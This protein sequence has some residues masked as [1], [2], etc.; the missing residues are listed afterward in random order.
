VNAS[1][2]TQAPDVAMDADGD[3]VVVWEDNTAADAIVRAQRFTEAG[4]A[5]GS[6]IAVNEPTGPGIGSFDPSVAIDNAGRFVVAWERFVATGNDDV[7]ARVFNASGTAQTAELPVATGTADQDDTE[8]AMDADGDVAIAWESGS[9]DDDVLARRY[10]SAGAPTTS[11]FPVNSTT[12]GTQGNVRVGLDAG[13]GSLAA[14]WDSDAGGDDEVVTRR[15]NSAGAPLSGE[16]AV[17]TTDAGDQAD[18]GLGVDA[19]GRFVVA[20]E[21]DG[22]GTDVIARAFDPVT[23]QPPDGGGGGPPPPDPQCVNPTT[24]L[25]SCANPSGRVPG[26]CGP[27]FASIFPACYLPTVPPTVC[28]PSF[29][30]ILQA[31]QLKEARILACGG[32]GTILPQCN[33]PP[34]SVPQVCGPSSGT[35]LPACTG[36]N[37]LVL[38]CGPSTGTV[39]PPCNFATKIKA[40]L[41]D[42]GKSE[43]IDL[44]LSCPPRGAQASQSPGAGAAQ[45]KPA[46][47]KTCPLSTVL[48]GSRKAL[49]AVLESQ[50]RDVAGSFF[51]V[52][53]GHR[54][55]DQA[56]GRR[57]GDSFE[58][59]A[60]YYRRTYLPAGGKAPG[61]EFG[62]R[63]RV[64]RGLFAQKPALE[65]GSPL[66]FYPY[67]GPVGIYPPGTNA[68]NAPIYGW[69]RSLDVA[70]NQ[71]EKLVR[72]A[73]SSSAARG[74]QIP[75]AQSARL[76]KPRV[77]K[78]FRIRA[79][80]RRRVRLKLSRKTVGALVKDARRRRA[81]RVPVRI[82]V[83]YRGK[84]SGRRIPVARVIDLQLRVKKAKPK[85][86]KR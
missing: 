60:E 42:P 54:A 53:L 19:S 1:T 9:P 8:S 36:G 21:S 77:T 83:S 24:L 74:G 22:T 73:K 23:A 40:G 65:A 33:L 18:P 20:W 32:F 39:L 44:T 71:Y 41:L 52:A 16:V 76:R 78:R 43:T 79:G 30:T 10:N 28:G 84:L 26:V 66:H 2:A 5:D 46:K 7:Y 48:E 37:N 51:L 49:D 25:V 70:A 72:E 86:K 59:R 35:I 47:P 14:T 75:G 81:K 38:A 4:V 64:Q 56:S 6:V 82:I 80:K 50:A 34:T 17:N 11:A 61:F 45:K 13:G 29:G 85:R 57:N 12:A 62:D 55:N 68:L 58:G 31:C 69:V 15:F 67:G 3:F 63:T 27:S